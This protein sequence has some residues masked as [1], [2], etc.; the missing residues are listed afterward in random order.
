MSE[1]MGDR[2]RGARARQRINQAELARMIGISANAMNA[3]EADEVDPRISRILRI[4]QVLG[5][6]MDYLVGHSV[7]RKTRPRLESVESELFPA[8]PVRGAA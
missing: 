2:I 3:I 5:V 1:T 4:A 8:E 7:K 6:S